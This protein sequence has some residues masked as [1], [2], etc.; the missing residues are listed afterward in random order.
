MCRHPSEGFCPVE[1]EENVQLKTQLFA[2]TH[3]THYKCD[4]QGFLHPSAVL[5]TPGAHQGTQ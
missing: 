3:S 1:A 2:H 5:C 4:I